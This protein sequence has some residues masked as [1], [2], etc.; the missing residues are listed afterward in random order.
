MWLHS[1]NACGALTD[2]QVWMCGAL[3]PA[4]QAVRQSLTLPRGPAATWENCQSAARLSAAAA[5]AHMSPA[6]SAYR[7]WLPGQQL[8][9]TNRGQSTAQVLMHVETNRTTHSQT[10]R[11]TVTSA[12]Y[13]GA[14]PVS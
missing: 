5:V 8:P 1:P 10:N 6:T 3:T 13:H 4:V 14:A 12:C 9:G 2:F 7:T 11:N